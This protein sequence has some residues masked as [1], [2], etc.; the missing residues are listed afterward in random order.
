MSE[1]Q[2]TI[3]LFSGHLQRLQNRILARPVIKDLV[4]AETNHI[5]PGIV[6]KTTKVSN[7]TL[8]PVKNPQLS[9]KSAP[10]LQ[11]VAAWIF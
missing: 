2:E 10:S 8:S 4:R 7:I 5:G 1:A 6:L 9:A 3:H 11:E